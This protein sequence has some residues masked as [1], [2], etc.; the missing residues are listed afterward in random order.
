MPLAP[1]TR[2][3]IAAVV[4]IAAV[5]GVIATP[6][7][8]AER[9]DSIEVRQ[10]PHVAHAPHAAHPGPI[11]PAGMGAPA[12]MAAAPA[13]A[14]D[15]PLAWTLPADWAVAPTQQMRL[16]NFTI[17]GG[18]A[19]GLFLFPGGGDRLANV[20]RWRGQAGLPPLDAAA[21]DQALSAGTCGFG[22]FHWLPIRGEKTS[23][24]A[25]IVPTPTGQCF[26][27]LEAAGERLDALRDGFLA[28]TTSLRPAGQAP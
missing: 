9:Q 24:L 11:A 27:K 14:A 1:Q 26:V 20:N 3:T 23:F 4:L 28:F 19:C 13:P 15:G 2:W 7:L 22:P 12:G 18:G 25:A 8:F 5:L 16:A 17:A 21:L 10:V 6:L